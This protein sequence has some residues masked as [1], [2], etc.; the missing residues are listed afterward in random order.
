[1]REACRNNSL[2]GNKIFFKSMHRSL[3]IILNICKIGVSRC[4]ILRHQITYAYQRL[5][6][7]EMYE[8]QQC[9]NPVLLFVDLA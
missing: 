2:T 4:E 3:L 9:L 8:Y 7:L 5:H 6:A 1:M